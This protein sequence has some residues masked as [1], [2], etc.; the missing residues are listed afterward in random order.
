MAPTGVCKILTT[1]FPKA[2]TTCTDAMKPRINPGLELS[3]QGKPD[4]RQK[5]RSKLFFIRKS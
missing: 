5:M 4:E 3:E 1:F 2:A